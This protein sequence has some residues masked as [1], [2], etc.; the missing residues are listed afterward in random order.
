LNAALQSLHKKKNFPE[1]SLSF[2]I[3]H[4]KSSTTFEEAYRNAD[5]ALYTAKKGG[6]NACMTFEEIKTE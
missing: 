4:K 3:S 5:R 1:V 6:G 2:G